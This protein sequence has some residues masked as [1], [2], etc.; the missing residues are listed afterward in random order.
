MGVYVVDVYFRY[1]ENEKRE[2]ERR[3]REGQKQV[4][5]WIF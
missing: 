1:K 2:K 5:F 3:E 4:Q